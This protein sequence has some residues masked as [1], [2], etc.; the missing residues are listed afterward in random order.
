MYIPNPYFS[1]VPS[2]GDLEMDYIIVENDCPIVFICK[3]KKD[4]I[5]FCNCVTM[6]EIQKWLITRVN[7]DILKEYFNNKISN[8][9]IFN[10]SKNKIFVVTW[11]YECLKENYKIV[12]NNN[13]NDDELPQKNS[14]LD[15]EPGEFDDYLNILKNRYISELTKSFERQ[16]KISDSIQLINKLIN[17]I[18]NYKDVVNEKS[19][20]VSY[21]SS[22]CN[23]RTNIDK[24]KKIPKNTK[25]IQYKN[26]KDNYK[27]NI[28]KAS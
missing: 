6:V 19:E 15:A 8:Y 13:L 11:S 24:I 20:K 14:F 4:Q 3:D 9:Q 21:E 27:L 5:Y 22:F 16:V 7:E 1:N 26:T 10:N 25:K 17:Y 2:I 12:S 28:S 18:P 23:S